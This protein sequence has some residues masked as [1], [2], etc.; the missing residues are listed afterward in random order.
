MVVN[1]PR[2]DPYLKA[3]DILIVIDL[4]G[5]PS[6][7]I[8]GFRSFLGTPK[9]F[10]ICGVGWCAAPSDRFSSAIGNAAKHLGKLGLECAVVVDDDT[11]F[12]GLDG[13]GGGVAGGGEG[14][15]AGLEVDDVRLACH[16][17]TRV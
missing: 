16:S 2:H 14:D 1:Y 15:V 9:R 8:G 12:A 4:T 11:H 5:S 3:E 10:I 13:L 7:A 17:P 6:R